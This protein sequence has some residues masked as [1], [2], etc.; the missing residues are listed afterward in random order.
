M[1]DFGGSVVRHG[2][3]YC[4]LAARCS[5]SVILITDTLFIHYCRIHHPYRYRYRYCNETTT[6]L[7][8]RPF[9][10]R[11]VVTNVLFFTNILF[12]QCQPLRRRTLLFT[13]SAVYTNEECTRRTTV[14]APCLLAI[15]SISAKPQPRYSTAV[16]CMLNWPS[17]RC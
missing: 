2:I 3:I 8:V 14:L 9:A 6:A 1:I 4:L 15:T 7:A 5:V 16:Q 10:Q 17:V 12:V 11:S 13:V